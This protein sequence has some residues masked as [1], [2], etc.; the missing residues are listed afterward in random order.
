MSDE[1]NDQNDE[2]ME[3]LKQVKLIFDKF[4]PSGTTGLNY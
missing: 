2:L 1:N 4:D 3:H